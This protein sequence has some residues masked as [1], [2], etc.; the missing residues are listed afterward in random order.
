MRSIKTTY[1]VAFFCTVLAISLYGLSSGIYAANIEAKLSTNDGSDAFDVQDSGGISLM[2]VFSNGNVGIGTIN[3]DVALCIEGSPTL[4]DFL[5]KITDSTATNGFLGFGEGTVAANQYLPT[6]HGRAHGTGSPLRSGL[7]LIGDAGEDGTDDEAIVFQGRNATGGLLTNANIFEV[8][9]ANQTKLMVMNPAGNVGIGTTSPTEKL[10]V[11]GTVKATAFTGDGASLTNIPGGTN[12]AVANTNVTVVDAGADDEYISFSEDGT[13][14]MRITGGNVGIGTTVPNAP[15]QVSGAT[16]DIVRITR[17]T[18]GST[19]TAGDIGQLTI[20]GTGNPSRYGFHLK[21]KVTVNAP[22]F[23]L[24]DLVIATNQNSDTDVDLVTIKNNGNFGI[25]TTTPGAKLEVA[26]QV[27]ITG[28]VPGLGKILTSNASG[29]AT[30]EA[31]TG[32]PSYGNSASSPNDAV[33]ITDSGNVG[34]GTTVPN[35]PLQ[36]SGAT[37]DIVRITRGT[38]GSTATAG[39]IG[40]LTISGTGNPSRFGFHIKSKVTVNSP[41]FPLEDLTIAT[42]QSS[43]TDVDLVTIK[44]NGNF[45]IGLTAPAF[46]FHVEG[47]DIL[48]KRGGVGPFTSL[49][50]RTDGGN[51]YV[52]N[53]DGF[54]GN[55]SSGNGLLIFTGQDGTLFNYGS[56]GSIGTEAMRIDNTGNVGI[57]TSS[58]VSNLDVKGGLALNI[59]TK[60]SAYTATVNDHTILCNTS[61]GIFTV[62]LPVAANCT[63]LILNIRNIDEN[64]VTI[65]PDTGSGELINDSLDLTV[66]DGNGVTIQ[67]DGANWW[68]ISNYLVLAF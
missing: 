59:V 47:D 29:L 21:S 19:Q 39:D 34:I 2:S 1:I 14:E 55:G 33:F 10:E 4:G 46:K 3:P 67:C 42:N 35:A 62:T 65:D 32:D 18:D 54:L 24:E 26:G 17:G 37:D 28:G 49:H 40:Q 16:D 64:E 48:L 45:G 43:D 36:V 44:N 52:N 20:S 6:I 68:V 9:D 7:K 5:L 41:Q 22:N 61:G 27:K 11:S 63:G 53:K 25:G 31:A 23:P 56:A 30:W 12:V 8:W 50:L 60:S 58:P 66:P 38:D 15:L 13:E 57:G 51:S